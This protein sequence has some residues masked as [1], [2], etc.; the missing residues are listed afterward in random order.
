MA[1]IRRQDLRRRL[2]VK[3]KTDTD[4]RFWGRY[5]HVTKPETLRAA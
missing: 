4:W 1:S 3:A 2:H 5:V